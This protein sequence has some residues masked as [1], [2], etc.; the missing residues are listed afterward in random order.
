M[1]SVAGHS[2]Q[3]DEVQDKDKNTDEVWIQPVK[4]FLANLELT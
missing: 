4:S 3:I 2:Y 1:S